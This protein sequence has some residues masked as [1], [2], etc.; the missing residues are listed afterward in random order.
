MLDFMK[1]IKVQAMNDTPLRYLIP[2]VR[3]KSH[4]LILLFCSEMS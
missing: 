3:L 4:D 1:L 2:F